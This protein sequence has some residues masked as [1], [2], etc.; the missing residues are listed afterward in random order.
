M[1]DWQLYMKQ[2]ADAIDKVFLERWPTSGRRPEDMLAF[3]GEIAR[4]L[5]AGE[6]MERM[7]QIREECQKIIDED[8]KVY[9]AAE[10]ASLSNQSTADE[11]MQYVLLPS[12]LIFLF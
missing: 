11:H 5:L 12:F 7:D 3:R 6:S 10:A 2:E 1:A 9:D 4:E 8:L